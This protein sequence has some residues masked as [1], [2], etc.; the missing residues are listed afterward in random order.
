MGMRA[1]YRRLP[2]EEFEKLRADPEQADA[3]FGLDIAE[4]D[5]ESIDAY[6]D[7]LETSGRY[8]DIQKS[9][10][11]V[12]FLLTGKS[13]MEEESVPPPLGNVVNGGA[14]TDWEASYGMVRYLTPQEVKE[15]AVA[16]DQISVAD[17]RQR[18][19]PKAFQAENIYP[20][21]E[22]WDETGIEHLLEV[23][24]RVRSFFSEAAQAGDMV[25]LSCD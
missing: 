25:L 15:V 21:A 23:F 16:L 2:E 24:R 19:D 17:L 20:G 13:A 14:D 9:W 4:E 10:D 22:V 8:L 5:D 6:Y 12:H 7:H 1:T 11:G 3:Y 18:Y